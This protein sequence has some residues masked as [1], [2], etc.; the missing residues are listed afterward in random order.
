MKEIIQNCLEYYMETCM[1][2][3]T[4]LIVVFMLC[5]MFCFFQILDFIKQEADDDSRKE[6]QRRF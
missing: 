2:C 4:I 3:L 5:S 6:N 1:V